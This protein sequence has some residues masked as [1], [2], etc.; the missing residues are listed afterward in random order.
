MEIEQ[1]QSLFDVLAT[2]AQFLDIRRN[3]GLIDTKPLIVRS[4]QLGT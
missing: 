4:I 1:P 3:R 2:M